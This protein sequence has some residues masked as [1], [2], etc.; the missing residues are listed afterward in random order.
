MEMLDRNKDGSLPFPALLL[1]TT[2]SEH[3][4]DKKIKLVW[5]AFTLNL[6]TFDTWSYV[7]VI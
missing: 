3:R 6:F 4:L 7:S 5:N 2:V 1:I